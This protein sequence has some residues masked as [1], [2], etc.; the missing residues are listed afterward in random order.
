M[1]EEKFYRHQ[2]ESLNHLIDLTI[3]TSYRKHPSVYFQI[4]EMSDHQ[5]KNAHKALL[6]MSILVLSNIVNQFASQ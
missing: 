1:L 6:P 3:E 2:I 5:L 4:H